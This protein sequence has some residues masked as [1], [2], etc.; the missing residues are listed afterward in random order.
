VTGAGRSGSGRPLSGDTQTVTVGVGDGI[1]LA[2]DHQSATRVNMVTSNDQSETANLQ[3]IHTFSQSLNDERVQT[4]SLLQ[5]CIMVRDG[6]AH[7]PDAFT[8]GDVSDI[9]RY[10]SVSTV[11]TFS[12]SLCTTCTTDI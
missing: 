10:W 1:L 9:A 2:D 11:L 4:A 8:A 3:S 7:L 6:L 12:L 5:E